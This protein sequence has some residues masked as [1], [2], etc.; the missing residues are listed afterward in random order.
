[1][2][3]ET[4][5][6]GLELVIPTS[7]TTNWAT[8]LKN[9]TWQKIND[10]QHTG[11]GDGNKLTGASF[12]DFSI[13]KT[14]LEKNFALTQ[15][16]KTPTGSTETID[17]DDGSKVILDLSSATADV[18][19]TINNPIEGGCYRIEVVQGATKRIVAWPASVQ[20][21]QGEEPSQYMEIN[22]RNLVKLDYDG[23]QYLATWEL[24]FS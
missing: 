15:Q 16:T 5:T 19:L 17:W 7:G 20:F 18:A 22:T 2:G 14:Q 6:G 10:H 21:P 23:T 8:V 9:S 24:D 1:M 13:G 3:Y 4:L 12:T 11:G